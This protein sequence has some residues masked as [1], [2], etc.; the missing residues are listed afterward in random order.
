[1]PVEFR[2]GRPP[3]WNN[4]YDLDAMCE[5]YFEDCKEN[6]KHPGVVGLA[7]FLGVD[8]QTILDYS[9]KPEFS[10]T[11]KKA[12]ARVEAYLEQHLYGN[13]VTG[14]IFNLKNNFG[15]KD[16]TE[17]ESSGPGGG[18][19]EHKEIPYDPLEASRAYQKMTKGS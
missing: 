3:H 8:R 10:G 7:V 16:K 15:W 17:V 12:K 9:K 19:I 2:T 18:P 11:I 14:S 6:D 4:C 1:M 5:M 13:S